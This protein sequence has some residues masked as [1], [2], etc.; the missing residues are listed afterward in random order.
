MSVTLESTHFETS[1]LKFFAKLNA[2]SIIQITKIQ[3]KKNEENLKK[4]VSDY[5][6]RFVVQIKIKE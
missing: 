6:Y 5:N 4:Y 3:K 1:L 2:V